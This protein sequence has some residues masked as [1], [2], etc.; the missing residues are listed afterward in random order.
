MRAYRSLWIRSACLSGGS[1]LGCAIG[2]ETMP[3][4]LAPMCL[5][6]HGGRGALYHSSNAL[7]VFRCI[8]AD[9]LEEYMRVYSV[10]RCG[11]GGKLG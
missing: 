9:G 10:I 5:R 2:V 6:L 11:G 4:C 3:P 7:D 1:W 8:Y